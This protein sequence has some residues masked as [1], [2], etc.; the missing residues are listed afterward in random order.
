[1]YF[2]LLFPRDPPKELQSNRW[3]IYISWDTLA[4]DRGPQAQM[5]PSMG[6]RVFFWTP[7]CRG[8]Y[9]LRSGP[10]GAPLGLVLVA[11]EWLLGAETRPERVQR[12]LS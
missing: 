12:W 9:G 3:N 6:G 7:F 8:V 2:L 10:L 1:M 4:I 11:N 5:A